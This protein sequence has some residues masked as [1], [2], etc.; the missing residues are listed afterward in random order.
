MEKPKSKSAKSK[1]HKSKIKGK[2]R[3]QKG[4]T[5]RGENGENNGLVHL[6]FFCF[7][8]SLKNIRISYRGGHKVKHG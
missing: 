7:F 4:K 1:K 8:S 6:H 3:K 2:K 5:K